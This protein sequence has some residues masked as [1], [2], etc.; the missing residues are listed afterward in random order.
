MSELRDGFGRK[1]DY[2]RISVTDR[3]NL[4]CRYCAPKKQGHEMMSASEIIQ[5][6]ELFSLAGISKFKITGGEP[7]L[8]EDIGDILHGIRPFAK[9]LTL[10]TN[11]ILL[12]ERDVSAAESV[13][14]SLDTLNADRYEALTGADMLSRVLKNINE[15]KKEIHINCIPIQGVNEDELCRIAMMTGDSKISVRFIELMPSGKAR[16]MKGIPNRQVMAVIEK[17]LG[18]LIPYE[19]RGN[20]PAQ[21]Y[22]ID[23]LSGKIGFISPVSECFCGSCNRIRLSSSGSLRL[24]LHHNKSYDIYPLLAE[25]PLRAVEEIKKIIKKKPADYAGFNYNGLDGLWNIGG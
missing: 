11:G 9:S 18:K 25:E 24:C 23:G 17:G 13:N 16:D 22:R 2:L 21:Y 3:C 20:G 12:D 4:N 6:A 5:A 1:I 19:S 7:L 15:C 10:T 8:R 14:I